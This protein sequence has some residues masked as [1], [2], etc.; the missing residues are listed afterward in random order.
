ML[1]YFTCKK[2]DQTQTPTGLTSMV[3]GLTNTEK[4]SFSGGCFIQ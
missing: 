1:L 3:R 2:K 4:K